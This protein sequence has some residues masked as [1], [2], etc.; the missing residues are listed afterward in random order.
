ME[1]ESIPHKIK[2]KKKSS[3]A[4]IAQLLV[5]HGACPPQLPS[6]WFLFFVCDLVAFN[7]N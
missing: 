1:I 2:K 3:V 4:W 5:C 7:Y 6:G